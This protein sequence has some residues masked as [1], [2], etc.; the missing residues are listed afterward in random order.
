MDQVTTTMNT[1]K[2]CKYWDQNPVE[3]SIPSGT[4]HRECTC[5]KIDGKADRGEDSVQVWG[6]DATYVNIA[7][8]PDFG[9][10]HWESK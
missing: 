10:I 6:E 3:Y 1:C 5:P 7:T 8:G 9:C 2:D 4:T